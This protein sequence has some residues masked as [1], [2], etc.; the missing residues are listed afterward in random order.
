MKLLTPNFK[1]EG[2]KRMGTHKCSRKSKVWW[3]KWGDLKK[4]IQ[5]AEKQ[6]SN[7]NSRLI[8]C[9]QFP[10]NWADCKIDPSRY[11]NKSD[12]YQSWRDTILVKRTCCS[13]QKHK[14][15]SWNIH[16]LRT[17]WNFSSRG[18]GTFLW[19]PCG[20]DTWRTHTYVLSKYLC[21]QMK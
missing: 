18:S 1:A 15:N 13:C 10:E 11:R 20:P 5:Q 9:F 19:T 16:K 3:R 14:I 7:F 17:M 8:S 12:L 2:N 4:Q 6:H 21:T